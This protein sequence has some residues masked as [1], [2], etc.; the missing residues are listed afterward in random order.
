MAAP[1]SGLWSQLNANASDY[2]GAL[3]WGTGISG[4]YADYGEGPPLG[5]TGR[6][7]TETDTPFRDVPPALLPE[8]DYGYSMEDI[9]PGDFAE[10]MTTDVPP[11]NVLPE[12][13]RGDAGLYPPPS[14]VPRPNGPSGAWL[15]TVHQ[16]GMLE[17]VGSPHSYPTETVTEGWDNK[18]SG[19]VLTAG[20]SSPDQ[21]ERQTS[22]QQVNPAPGRNNQ[23]A[24]ERGTDDPRANIM[25]RLT[26]MKIKPWSEGERLGDMFPYQ[27]D[28][29][30]RPFWFR[31]AATGPVEWLIT[32]EYGQVLPIQRNPPPE[33]YYGPNE[34]QGA[35]IPDYGYQPEDVIPYA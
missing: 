4:I 29:I 18:L 6:A 34:S 23:A 20:T 25:T 8:E 7:D 10:F 15:R 27:Q 14:L 12:T 21:Y 28:M 13:R 31:N 30:L 19:E 33:P 17:D 26:G 11:W 22:M 16:P 35:D 2:S 5:M 32:N 24:V 3:K 1:V 9:L